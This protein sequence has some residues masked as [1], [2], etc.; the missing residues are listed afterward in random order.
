M[1][2]YRIVSSDNHVFEPADLWTARVEPK[3]KDRAPH[4]RR[5]EDGADWWWCDGQKGVH[6]AA[7]AQAGLRFEDPSKLTQHNTFEDVLLGG[8]IPE[9][10]VKDLDVDG[11][12]VSI[13]YPTAALVL[14]NL[15][16]NELLTSLFGTYNDW[17]ADF[18]KDY[19]ERLKGIG[20]L[21]EANVESCVKELKRCAKMGLPG[22]TISVYPGEGRQYYRPE[23]EPLW[24]EAQDLQM[25]LSLHISTN[26]PGVG[27]EHMDLATTT[28][29]FV[30]NR[31]HW[32]RMSLGDII[33]SGVFE[34]Y[35]DLQIGSVEMG[36]SWVPH[37]LERIDYTYT[38][39]PRETVPY[40]FKGDMVPS[41]YFH[42]NVFL[43]FQDDALGI[44]MRD[45]IGVDNLQWGADYPHQESTF[46]RSQEV[47]AEIL[48]DCTEEEKAKIVGGNAARIYHLD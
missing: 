3:Y 16:D 6:M 17:L 27:Q 2:K 47:I 11:V 19:P 40:R 24:A 32:V 8:Y 39:Y 30:S 43:G 4:I 22:A 42:R 37:F 20:L 21:N 5:M 1:A 14:Y 9:E 44:Q 31:D 15:T 48:A 33:F 23:Y 45:I 25:P 12:D 38:E 10:H 13:I 46:P 7:G 28:P 26:R 35:P 18:C 36:L 29:S 34:R 41:D